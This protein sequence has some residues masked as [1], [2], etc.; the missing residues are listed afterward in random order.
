MNIDCQLTRVSKFIL[1]VT[2]NEI[3]QNKRYN[4]LFNL[5]F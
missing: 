5:L 2:S 1:I 4:S 3:A